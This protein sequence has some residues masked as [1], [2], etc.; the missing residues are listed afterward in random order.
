MWICT[1]DS[2]EAGLRVAVKDLIDVAGLPTTA[3]SRAVAA[4]AA[5]AASDASCLAG[6]RA[7]AAR[8]EAHFVGKTNLHELAYGISGINARVR[9]AGQPARPGAGPGR[10]VER[11]G[12]GG[13]QRRSRR[14]FRLGHRRLDPHPGRLLRGGRAEDHAGAG[15]R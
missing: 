6:L 14:C 11:V 3:G 10:L 1:E 7:A 13:G 5:P 4:Q 8:G 2:N 12:G 9:H 15:Y